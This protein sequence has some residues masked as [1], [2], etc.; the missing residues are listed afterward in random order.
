MFPGPNQVVIKVK[1]VG[2]NT[3]DVMN[4]DHPLAIQDT[5]V[6]GSDFA[7]VVERVGEDIKTLQDPRVKIGTRVAG[8]VQGGRCCLLPFISN[9]CV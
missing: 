4:V 2:L 3:V 6:V 9:L 7:G 5:R 8:F 1:A